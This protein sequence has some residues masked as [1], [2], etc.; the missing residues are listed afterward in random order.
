MIV[1]KFGQDWWKYVSARANQNV[2][3][4]KKKEEEEE[5]NWQKQKPVEDFVYDWLNI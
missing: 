4:R 2:A 3:R 5:R 1:T